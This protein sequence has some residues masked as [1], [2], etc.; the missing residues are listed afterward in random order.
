MTLR[1]RSLSTYILANKHSMAVSHVRVCAMGIC[2]IPHDG[3]A[4]TILVVR[5]IRQ[6]PADA[7]VTVQA[8][9]RSHDEV[10]AS[11]TFANSIACDAKT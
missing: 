9:A 1:R 7:G 11:L 3:G 5:R 10:S 2:S 8:F 6:E 4:S